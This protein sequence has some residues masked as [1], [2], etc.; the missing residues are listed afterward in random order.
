MLNLSK[1]L[2]KNSL[3]IKPLI[4]QG[5]NLAFLV[6]IV[7]SMQLSHLHAQSR[8]EATAYHHKIEYQNAALYSA[9]GWQD[10]IEPSI[11]VMLTPVKNYSGI[12]ANAQQTQANYYEHG[13]MPQSLQSLF[14]DLV[15]STRLLTIEPSEADIVMSLSINHYTH[16]LSYAPDDD[17]Y[18]TLRDQVDRWGV[19]A[20]HATV[21]LSLKMTSKSH[22][23]KPWISSVESTL[24][25]CDLNAITHSL[26]PFNQSDKALQAY[27]QSTMGQAF[28]SASNYLLVQ[29]VEKLNSMQKRAR[30]VDN[31]HNELL[32]QTNH[33]RFVAGKSYPLFYQHQYPNLRRQPVGSVQIVK[34][35]GQQAIAY[36]IDLRPDHIKIGDWVEVGLS[37]PLDKP[38]S[39]FQAKNKCAT[40][41]TAKVVT[42]ES[43][44]SQQQNSGG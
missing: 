41:T 38:K 34:S 15:L 30:V 8:L 2:A 16:P 27:T 33:G 5:L 19:T 26:L 39:R 43:A 31:Q 25:N 44:D 36:P 10:T 9:I 13:K 7:F 24:S 20:K 37:A 23:F 21:S 6:V 28:V 40:V 14:S 12:P 42:A 18:Q 35:M 32:L 29:A 22:R 11:N 1:M 3:P 17:W 4:N